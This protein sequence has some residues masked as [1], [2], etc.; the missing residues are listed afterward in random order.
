MIGTKLKTFRHVLLILDNDTKGKKL[1]L[2]Q[3]IDSINNMMNTKYNIYW[4]VFDK[5]QSKLF[6]V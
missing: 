5:L 1:F 4:S 2:S 6:M 3:R